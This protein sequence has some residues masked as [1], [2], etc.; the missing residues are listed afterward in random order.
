MK[1]LTAWG[2]KLELIFAILQLFILRYVNHM[3]TAVFKK[4]K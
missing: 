2:K 1:G 4:Q 3:Q